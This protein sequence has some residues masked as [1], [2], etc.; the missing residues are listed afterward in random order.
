MFWVLNII[1]Q[2]YPHKCVHWFR[3]FL[4]IRSSHGNH[5]RSAE[6]TNRP[7]YQEIS[8]VCMTAGSYN[9][10]WFPKHSDW[11]IEYTVGLSSL[12]VNSLSK[13]SIWP[14]PPKCL[15]SRRW[16]NWRVPTM[17]LLITLKLSPL[18]SQTFQP[19]TSSRKSTRLSVSI[20]LYL[21]PYIAHSCK[22]LLK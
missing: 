9:K 11:E 20:A 6:T 15:C 10:S 13:A 5:E 8:L 3:F 2:H 12:I 17:R 4:T 19:P 22:F 14:M 7:R 16:T 18:S 1:N 21:L